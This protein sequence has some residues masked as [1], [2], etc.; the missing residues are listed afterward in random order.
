LASVV[1][2]Y[3]VGVTWFASTE[4]RDSDAAKLQTACGVMALALA[5]A[6][7]W[8]LEWPDGTGSP[9]FVYMIVAFGFIVGLPALRACEAPTPSL[10]QRAVKRAVL[11]LVA[12]DAVL[13]TAAAGLAGLVLLLLLPPA[14][15]LGRRVYST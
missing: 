2:L 9:L 14:I 3:I 7:F 10:V 6:V 4:A 13:A 11:G 8:P 5:L 1:G 12:L 15:A